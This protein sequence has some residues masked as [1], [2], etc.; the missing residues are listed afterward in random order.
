MASIL[1]QWQSIIGH[2]VR[3]E[4]MEKAEDETTSRSGPSEETAAAETR[5]H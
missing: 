3:K 4:K 5:S 1:P 2:S